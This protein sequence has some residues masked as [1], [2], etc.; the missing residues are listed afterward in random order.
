MWYP[1]DTE[2]A[3]LINAVWEI[4]FPADNR[5]RQLEWITLQGPANSSCSVYLDTIFIDTTPRGDLNH[6]EYY[7]GIPI[8]GGRILRLVWNVG[9]G[10]PPV[11]TIGCTDGDTGIAQALGASGSLVSGG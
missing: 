5:G 10:A 6:A 8:A 11:A 4:D 7:K 1:L 9:T 3:K 2:T